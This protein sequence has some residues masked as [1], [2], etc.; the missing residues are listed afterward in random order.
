MTFSAKLDKL[1]D[2]SEKF[3]DFLD[4]T[5]ERNKD[6]FTKQVADLG[7]NGDVEALKLK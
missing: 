4:S 3:L 1:S 7:E 2:D 6:D 5:I